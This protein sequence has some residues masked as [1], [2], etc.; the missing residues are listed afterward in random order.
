MPSTTPATVI[1]EITSEITAHHRILA[2]WLS[3]TGDAGALE[4]FLAAHADDFSLVTVGGEVVQ[5][6]ALSD[7]LIAGQGTCPGLR[8]TIHDVVVVFSSADA[9]LVRFTERHQVDDDIDDRVVSALLR[10]D[11]TAPRGLRWQ[12]VHETAG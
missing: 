12:H 9:I 4:L 5:G 2:E 1:S 7:G 8:I 10:V 3:G 11:D 6:E